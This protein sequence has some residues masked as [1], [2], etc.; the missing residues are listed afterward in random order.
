[1][2][3]KEYEQV[4]SYYVND[5]TLAST[6][7]KIYTNSC[8]ESGGRSVGGTAYYYLKLRNTIN[9]Q[10]ICISIPFIYFRLSIY[11]YNLRMW[12]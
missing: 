8:Y 11:K 3:Q 5:R 4:Q 6:V 7:S 9:V 2:A 10:N 1:M 12:K